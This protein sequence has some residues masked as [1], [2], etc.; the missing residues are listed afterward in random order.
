MSMVTDAIPWKPY[1]GEKAYEAM[2]FK[3]MMKGEFKDFHSGVEIDGKLYQSKGEKDIKSLFTIIYA[4]NKLVDRA[5]APSAVPNDGLLEVCSLHWGT[6]S[7]KE[8]G[9]SKKREE[10]GVFNNYTPDKQTFYR[11]K[12]AIITSH[13]AD[14]VHRGIISDGEVC[15][16][17]DKFACVDVL[18]GEIELLWDPELFFKSYKTF[19]A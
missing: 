13:E 8:L 17:Y 19:D 7:M 3:S 1:L 9:E 11:G 14:P 16:P 18:P 12:R 6:P 4:N 15:Q 10:A 2:M 5:N